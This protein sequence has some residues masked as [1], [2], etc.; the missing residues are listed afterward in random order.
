MKVEFKI[1]DGLT[2]PESLESDGEFDSLATFRLKPD[3]KT[4]CLVAIGETKL[5]G[6]DKE[7][8]AGDRAASRYR[9]KMSEGY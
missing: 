2:L 8:K 1:P 9:E 5:P 6:Y 7:E 4:L 3:G